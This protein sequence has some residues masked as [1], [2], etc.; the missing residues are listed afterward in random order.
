MAL[1]LFKIIVS[2]S[3]LVETRADLNIIS[4][5]VVEPPH[6]V[7]ITALEFNCIKQ[8]PEFGS[9]CNNNCSAIAT[10]CNQ[11]TP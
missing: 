3:T 5:T 4:T 10:M 9:A 8:T 6:T 7:A 2:P 1:F 11:T